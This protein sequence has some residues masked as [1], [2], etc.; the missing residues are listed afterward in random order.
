MTNFYLYL[1][2]FGFITYFFYLLHVIRVRRKVNYSITL[3]ALGIVF[4]VWSYAM[5]IIHN[6]DSILK[7][8]HI[9][10]IINDISWILGTSLFFL[11]HIQFTESKRFKN[12]IV[13]MS[14]YAFFNLL[15]I[16]TR[17]FDSSDL[18]RLQD[19][20]WIKPFKMQLWEIVF[21][22]YLAISF[23]ISLYLLFQSIKNSNSIVIRKRSY[24]LLMQDIVAAVLG[25]ILH[26]LIPMQTNYKFPAMG[27]LSLLIWFT[28]IVFS[29]NRYKLLLYTPSEYAKNNVVN[30]I[31][32]AVMILDQNNKI[33]NINTN[34]RILL[35]F[36]L[37]DLKGK[38]L[39]VLFK[40][41]DLLSSIANNKFFIN[42]NT[43][44]ISKTNKTLFLN[45]TFSILTDKEGFPSGYL[46]I[47]SER[48][49]IIESEKIEFKNLQ[50]LKLLSE[51][52]I[53]FVELAPDEDIYQYIGEKLK[54]IAGENTIIAVNSVDETNMLSTTMAVYGLGKYISQVMSLMGSHPLGRSYKI[55]PDEQL[56]L[57]YTGKLIELKGGM[58]ELT[59]KQIPERVC[60]AIERL[61]KL[62]RVY[63]IAFIWNGVMYGNA[64][65]I[66]LKNKTIKYPH[67]IE[68][69]A[70]QSS[71]ALQKRIAEQALRFSEKKYKSYIDNSPQSIF[72]IDQT[73]KILETNE[74]CSKLT[75]YEEIELLSMYFS[76]LFIKEKLN[77]IEGFI[78]KI[79]SEGK[80]ENIKSLKRKNAD[81]IYISLSAAAI[82]KDKYIVFCQDVNSNILANERLKSALEEKDVL[83]KEV[84]HRVKNNM[85]VIISLI[86]M[87]INEDT[88]SK[89]IIEKFRALQE[90]VRTM[91]F[92]HE[93]LYNSKDLSKIQFGN[94][95]KRL[96]QNLSDLYTTDKSIV[97]D[98]EVE[99]FLFD[100]NKAIPCGLVV[101]ELISNALK[102]AFK[103]RVREEKIIKIELKQE[104]TMYV[105]HVSDNGIGLPESFDIKNTESLGLWLVNI[106]VNDQLD[107][108]LTIDRNSGTRFSIRFPV[109]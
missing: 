76:E 73:Y 42:Q 100:I 108:S 7:N 79:K 38:T 37:S 87:Q 22:T 11:F 13:F 61:I 96:T 44:I 4:F 48:M 28:W 6:P 83:L 68:A 104:Q 105:L 72:I 97:F 41:K 5:I 109:G 33:Q 20:G 107:G 64:A 34:A 91:A 106:L 2:F 102:Y 17:S 62:E 32:K 75:Y 9:A 30:S 27:H 92:I 49:D 89:E 101:N 74:A 51:S 43:E 81:T 25:V 45:T 21:S 66:T 35:G 57:L 8:V 99:N 56:D 86:N 98:I 80:A 53:G 29:M 82:S 103:E 1:D 23:L 10:F 95:I 70:N 39:D 19:I 26:I 67:F 47:I 55:L 93:G 78:N 88:M 59:F 69:F 31:D 63:G 58:Y 60:K 12:K 24:Q 36:D 90:R 50:S 84:H 71:I 3:L 65:I 94:Y 40:D 18:L 15:L 52:A 85:Q 46:V 77:P 54:E 14:F 16:F